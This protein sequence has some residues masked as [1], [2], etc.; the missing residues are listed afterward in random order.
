MIQQITTFSMQ[1]SEVMS[2]L[3]ILF[4]AINAIGCYQLTMIVKILGYSVICVMYT[5]GKPLI[6]FHCYLGVY[7]DDYDY[8]DDADDGGDDGDDNDDD[9]DD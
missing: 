8:D 1:R 4:Y 2:I 7:D 9:D 5:P 6:C 3:N